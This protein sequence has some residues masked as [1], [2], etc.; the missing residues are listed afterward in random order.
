MPS[1]TSLFL[2]GS[3]AVNAALLG[4]VG[5]RL[6]SPASTEPTVQMQLE[7]YGPTSDVV[8][9]AWSQLPE[10]DRAELRKQLRESWVAMEDERKRLREAGEAVYS[11]AL[12]E[13]FDQNRLRDAVA[14]FQLREKHL[15]ENAE[16]ILISHLSKMP[17]QA[18][19]TAATGLLTPFNAR[20]QRANGRGASKD[21]E[22]GSDRKDA[23]AK[24]PTSA[25]NDPAKPAP[26][27]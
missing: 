1:K 10:S 15:Q 5:G 22:R 26:S 24:G 16:N 12:A 9:A 23:P 17:P 18:R 21:G 11:A 6:F 25:G 7:R 3:L 13:P 27:N 4:I 20:M 8:A 19:A 14:I 2:I